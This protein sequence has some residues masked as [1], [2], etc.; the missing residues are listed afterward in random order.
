MRAMIM[1]GVT[2]GEGAV[3]AAN[4]VVTKDVEPY[5]V[6]GG[7]PARLVKHRFAP[8][9]IE[10]LVALEIY[11]WPEDKFAAMRKFLTQP[12][13]ELLEKAMKDYDQK[14]V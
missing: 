5:S 6:V 11:Q 10:K 8:E 7:N 2:I 9:L 14:H 13:F 12:D 3:V 1:P 4:S